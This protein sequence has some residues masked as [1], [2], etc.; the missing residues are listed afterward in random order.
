MNGIK[1]DSSRHLK[2]AR[3]PVS[4]SSTEI[5][6][7]GNK[8]LSKRFFYV[9]KEEIRPLKFVEK[10]K[11]TLLKPSLV[12]YDQVLSK[13]GYPTVIFLTKVMTFSSIP[14]IY[15][16]L[17]FGMN[18]FVY[19]LVSFFSNFIVSIVLELIVIWINSFILRY[20]LK[21][22]DRDVKNFGLSPFDILFTSSFPF[23]LRN[24][25]FMVSLPLLSLNVTVSDP[26]LLVSNLGNLIKSVEFYLDLPL[27]IWCT[28]LIASGVSVFYK[29]SPK[30]SL[31][32]SS[33][34]VFITF[35][36]KL[37]FPNVVSP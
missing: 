23:V 20:L 7:E 33:I 15:V 12:F 3:I 29:I 17:N 18:H 14:F 1:G 24:V 8:M 30:D 32:V 6:L 11:Y 36:P 13:S 9:S 10:V 5:N 25:G 21:I 26:I 35:L 19:G 22:Y 16:V 2:E 27:Y 28:F 31:V 34:I 37:T 4:S